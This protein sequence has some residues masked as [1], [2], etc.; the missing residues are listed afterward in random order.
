MKNLIP[1]TLA[2]TLVASGISSAQTP[3]Y[4]KPSGYVTQ[5]LGV[6]F[7]LVGLTLQNP[8]AF[9]GVITSISGANITF[10][11]SLSTALPAGKMFVLEVTAGSGQSANVVQEFNTVSGS[12]ITLPTAI[13][14]LVQGNTVSIRIAPTLEELFG[15]L[16]QSQA[17]AG[18]SDIVWIPAGAGQYDRYYYKTPFFGA[19]IWTKIGNGSSESAAP[20]TPVVFLDGV[21]VQ[22][23]TSPKSLT[24]AGTVKTTP[25]KFGVATGFNLIGTNF[26]VGSTLKNSGFEAF[27][28]SQATAGGSDIIWI[29]QT[30]GSFSR[31]YYKTPF[32]GA[33]SWVLINGNTE[34]SVGDGSTI[35]LSSGIFVQRKG[36]ARTVTLVPPSSYSSL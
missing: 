10:G 33:A 35:N 1:I 23:K 24:L 28:Q 19:P 16:L 27:L 20:N 17:T 29:S 11:S 30:A 18:G 15:T 34:T 12:S 5:T 13:T 9:T 4:S 36:S 31:Y 26:P 32:F 6:G 8:P 2:A 25:S 14:D 3:A 7:N 21:F 22:I